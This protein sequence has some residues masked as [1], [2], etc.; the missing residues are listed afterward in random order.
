MITQIL[1]DLCISDAVTSPT[2]LRSVV[3]PDNSEMNITETVPPTGN[4]K[5]NLKACPSLFMHA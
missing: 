3:M 1:L 2:V 5:P 4:L